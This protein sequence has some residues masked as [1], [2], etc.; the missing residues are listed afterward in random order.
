MPDDQ[1]PAVEMYRDCRIHDCQSP[2]RIAVVKRELDEVFEISGIRRLDNILRDP[3]WAPE[4][5]LLAYAK[6]KGEWERAIEERIPRP[7]GITLEAA[8]AWTCS[9]DSVEWRDPINYAS[10]LDPDPPAA[11]R[12]P[13][14]RETPL[15]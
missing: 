10:D 4:S 15:R 2:S 9:L 3:G 1:L 7:T 11:L 13:V 12:S 14:R 5:R 6:F 8:T